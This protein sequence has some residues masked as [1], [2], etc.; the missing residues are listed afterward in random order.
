MKHCVEALGSFPAHQASKEFAS[1]RSESWNVVRTV[2][3][4]SF[5]ECL[6]GELGKRRVGFK[7]QIQVSVRQSA[8]GSGIAS[9]RQQPLGL[10]IQGIKPAPEKHF[11]VSCTVAPAVHELAIVVAACF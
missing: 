5:S 1:P 11:T 6:V 9:A 7:C 4:L 2:H 8:V 3:L 10:A